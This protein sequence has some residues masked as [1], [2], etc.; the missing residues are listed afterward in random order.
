[1]GHVD[2]V[3]GKFVGWQ[4]HVEMLPQVIELFCWLES[5]NKGAQ[6]CQNGD[7]SR[8][9]SNGQR[10]ASCTACVLRYHKEQERNH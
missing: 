8:P 2:L 7:R 6:N 5:F 4:P 10:I 1:M 3:E 9:P